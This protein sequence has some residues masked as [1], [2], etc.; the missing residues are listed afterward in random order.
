MEYEER[1]DKGKKRGVKLKVVFTGDNKRG[2]KDE[3]KPSHQKALGE[4]SN[5]I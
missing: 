5:S 3:Q 2:R 4:G 1:G